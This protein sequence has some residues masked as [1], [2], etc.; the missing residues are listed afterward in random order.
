MRFHGLYLWLGGNTPCIQ[1][2]GGAWTV[3]RSIEVSLHRHTGR[4]ADRDLTSR[5]PDPSQG[6]WQAEDSRV[7]GE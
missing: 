1:L 5:R 3:R 2:G 6:G 7:G 4:G